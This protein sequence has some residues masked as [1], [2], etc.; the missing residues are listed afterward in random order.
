M[1][2]NSDL[3][4]NILATI[5]YYDCLDYPL[6]SFEVWK[7]LIQITNNKEQKTDKGKGCLFSDIAGELDNGDIRRYIEECRGFYFLY[8]FF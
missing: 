1:F 7:Y 6:T 2:M 5:A 4:K 8:L 3:A